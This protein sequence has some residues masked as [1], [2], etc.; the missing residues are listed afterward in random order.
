LPGCG[1]AVISGLEATPTPVEGVIQAPPASD[2]RTQEPA[3]G[4]PTLEPYKFTDA[5]G[6]P[7]PIPSTEANPIL[8]AKMEEVWGSKLE[9]TA[10]PADLGSERTFLLR[11]VSADGRFIVGFDMPRDTNHE[12]HLRLVMMEV[13]TRDVTE[14]ARIPNPSSSG[15]VVVPHVSMDREWGAWTEGKLIRAYNMASGRTTQLEMTSLG[16]ETRYL[17]TVALRISVDSGV[18]VW[19]EGDYWDTQNGRVASVIKMADLETGKVSTIGE[20]G[21]R[22]VISGSN[23]LWVEPDL[24]TE[25]EGIVSSRIILHNLQTGER[26]DLGLY[27]WVYDIA[28]R[29]DSMVLRFSN[30]L[31]LQNLAQTRRQIMASEHYRENIYGYTIN[32]QVVAWNGGLTPM[33]WDRSLQRLVELRGG[34]AYMN[35]G[36]MVNGDNLAW[37]AAPP[38]G[39]APVTFSLFPEG[40]TIYLLDTTQL[41]K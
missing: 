40:S 13:S 31:T 10:I 34:V 4:E 18:V 37:Q 3:T 35:M 12:E 38:S 36:L 17:A 9:I 32:E 21:I 8:M 25:V 39:Q 6:V 29:G 22:P 20:H 14:I 2:Q 28:I 16:A 41:R 5:N 11:G 33:V 1:G 26:R 15:Y 24:T 27:H 7:F 30:S 23:V 19:A